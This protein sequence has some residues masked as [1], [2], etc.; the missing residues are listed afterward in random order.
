MYESTHRSKAPGYVAYVEIFDI[1][2]ND[3]IR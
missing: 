1:E 2:T 3:T